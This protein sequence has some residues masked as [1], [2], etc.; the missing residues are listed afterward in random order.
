MTNRRMKNMAKK[1]SKSVVGEL[2]V[3][4]AA[5][6]GLFGIQQATLRA[7]KAKGCPSVG[8][9]RWDLRQVLEWWMANIMASKT[10]EA[11]KDL[12]E[13]KKEYWEARTRSEVVK[14]ATLEEKYLPFEELDEEWGW[15]A[16]I[17]RAGLLA[18]SS[19]LPPLL[20]GKKQLQ[21]REILHKESCLLLAALSKDHQYCPRNA[22][23]KEYTALNKLAAKLDDIESKKKKTTKKKVRA[24]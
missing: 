20:V 6:S 8:H 23:P 3:S 19:R 7:W 11:D 4:S 2:T 16:G 17:Y 9:N 22:L 1:P 14:A 5:C 12:T 18:Y 10:E 24:K 15:R 13:I 21:M